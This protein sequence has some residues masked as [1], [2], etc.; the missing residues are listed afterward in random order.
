MTIEVPSY[1]SPKAA[2]EYVA[3]VQAFRARRQAREAAEASGTPLPPT[4]PYEP[5]EDTTPRGLGSDNGSFGG[6]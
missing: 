6:E 2:K 5:Y 1:L 3:W 4:K